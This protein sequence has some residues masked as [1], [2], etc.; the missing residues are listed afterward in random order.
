MK[1][2]FYFEEKQA[3][4]VDNRPVSVGDRQFAGANQRTTKL[5][6]GGETA[7]SVPVHDAEHARLA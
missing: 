4:R 1:K 7:R 5:R 6:L 2:Y 3:V